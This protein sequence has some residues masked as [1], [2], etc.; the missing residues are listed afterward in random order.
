MDAD[1]QHL[2]SELPGLIRHLAAGVHVVIGSYPE[3]GSPA[4][5][6]AWHLFRQ[7]TGLTF[8]DLTSGFRAYDL[9]AMIVLA[10]RE[11]SLVDYQDIGILLLLRKAGLD[12]VEHPVTMRPRLAGR[13]HIFSSWRVVFAYMIETT[14]LCLARWHVPRL[15]P[16]LRPR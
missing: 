12:I 13:S 11:A 15:Q 16:K 6:F 1:G 4:R 2:G 5:R 14:L 10:G 7:L 9:Q 3:R 8:A